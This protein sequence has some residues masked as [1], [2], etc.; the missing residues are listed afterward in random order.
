MYKMPVVQHFR[1]FNNE[2]INKPTV[3]FHYLYLLND[4]LYV[5]HIY[6][7]CLGSEIYSFPYSKH[8]DNVKK[9]RHWQYNTVSS[10]HQ[11]TNFIAS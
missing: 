6:F 5:I 1:T 9:K 3:A 4:Y 10:K 7:I 11:R 8:V 2:T